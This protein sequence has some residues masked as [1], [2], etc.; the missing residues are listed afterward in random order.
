MFIKPD[1]KLVL[2]SKS[3]RRQELIRHITAN[4]EVRIQDVEEN[5]DP[6]L[7]VKE[8]SEYL[9]RIKAEVL[10]ESLA[11]NEVIL[12]ADTVVILEGRILGKP[13]DSKHAKVM[14]A[15]ISGKKHRVITGCC[16]ISR[17]KELC[18]SEYTDVYFNEL[19]PGMI[20]YYVDTYQP[21]DRAGSYGI[22][23]WIGVVGVSRIDGCFYNVM[24]L[25]VSR[26]ISELQQF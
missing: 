26:L 16:L 4:Y 25:P 2:G 19:S 18:F 17:E 3:P 13:E 23:D 1:I 12:C 5:F 6:V 7:P 10:A 21:L 8:V 20:D 24:G 11:E 14:L 15:E 22:Q 9:A